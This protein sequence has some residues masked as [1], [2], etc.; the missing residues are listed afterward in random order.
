MDTV[1]SYDY[2]QL[3]RGGRERVLLVDDNNEDYS[4][5]DTS[6]YSDGIYVGYRRRW[7]NTSYDHTYEQSTASSI[8]VLSVFL[9]ICFL[10]TCLIVYIERYCP[11]EDDEDNVIGPSDGNT[12]ASCED[13][14]ED[15]SVL[16]DP[17]EPEQPP[18]V[19]IRRLPS[20]CSS[21]VA[22]NS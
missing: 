11:Q 22:D 2:H 14:S 10:T 6:H 1:Y 12:V 4:H 5:D 13:K 8:A 21:A 9:F 16:D 15:G 18:K 3:I 19:T 7:N 20:R 17:E